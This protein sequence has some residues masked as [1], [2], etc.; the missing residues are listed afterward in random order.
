M[1]VY[2][3]NI[4][5]YPFDLIHMIVYD[6]KLATK[7]KVSLIWLKK[8][9]VI[10]PHYCGGSWHFRFGP[11]VWTSVVQPVYLNNTVEL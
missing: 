7:I 4:Q 6:P 3:L 9:L 8:S 2:D 10:M 11:Y 5:C 1:P